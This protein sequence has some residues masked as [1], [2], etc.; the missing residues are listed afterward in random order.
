LH[1][2]F[3]QTAID[4]K[5]YFSILSEKLGFKYEKND[6]KVVEALFEKGRVH[7]AI[8]WAKELEKMH[9]GKPPSEAC[10]S[11]QVYALVEQLLQYFNLKGI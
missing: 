10:P 2:Q 4:R 8:K 3:L 11:T 6:I 5:A 1:F 7:Q 9:A